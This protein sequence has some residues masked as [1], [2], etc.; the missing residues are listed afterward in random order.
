TLTTRMVDGDL[1][2]R[3]FLLGAMGLSTATLL[4]ACA[5]GTTASS[6][7][8]SGASNVI[9][10]YTVENDPATLA[11]YNMVIANFKKDH[12]DMDVKVTV[13][14]DANQLQYLTTAFQN[15]VDLGIFSPAV[16]SFPEFA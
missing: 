9:P 8:G 2:R 14:A 15:G 7:S 5:G 6:G 16:S 10:F 13:Y 12:P 4:S 3:G 11:F 1:G